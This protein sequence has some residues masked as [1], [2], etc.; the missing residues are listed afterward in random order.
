MYFGLVQ[1]HIK[2]K[3]PTAQVHDRTC[4]AGRK[5]R[6]RYSNFEN[7]NFWRFCKVVKPNKGKANPFVFGKGDLRPKLSDVRKDISKDEFKTCEKRTLQAWA[8]DKASAK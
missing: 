3:I 5:P 1:A 7:S 4:L 6:P 8:N 2:P